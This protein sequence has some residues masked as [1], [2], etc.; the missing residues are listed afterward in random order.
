MLKSSALL[1]AYSRTL[2]GLR[3]MI[4]LLSTKTTKTPCQA[5]VLGQPA[6][7]RPVQAILSKLK[8]YCINF[9]V[10]FSLYGLRWHWGSPVHN[11]CF[12]HGI[13]TCCK[14]ALST[15]KDGLCAIDCA[16]VHIKELLNFFALGSGLFQCALIFRTRNFIKLYSPPV[17]NPEDMVILLR[18]SDV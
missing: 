16:C 10:P 12:A 9:N 1:K 15:T 7:N 13:N 8:Y 14:C 3:R 4:Q 17:W 5:L 6:H 2:K 18:H 11:E